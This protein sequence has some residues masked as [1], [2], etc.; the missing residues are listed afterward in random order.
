MGACLRGGRRHGHGRHLVG[1]PDRVPR[2][3]AVS[4]P[5]AG[6]GRAGRLSL[7][8]DP[9]VRG[10]QHRR[11]DRPPG[12]GGAGVR[13]RGR[14]G[15]LRR[16]WSRI[17]G[18][19]RGHRPR[20]SY[21]G[22]NERRRARVDGRYEPHTLRRPWDHELGLRDSAGVAVRPGVEG[23]GVEPIER[24]RWLRALSWS[25]IGWVLLSAL[26]CVA[27]LAHASLVGS[28]PSAGGEL[29]AP[30]EQVRLRFSEPVFAEFDPVEVRDEGGQ[31]VD[32]G[33]ARV[34]P[35]DARAVVASLEELREGS[36]E[37][38]WR[39]PPWTATS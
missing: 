30:P 15:R 14:L 5:V 18:D 8:G 20:R 6:A 24:T 17:S 37:V 19:G 38:Q 21:D 16:T 11:V 22:R 1:G 26:W 27:A 9:D 25:V 3:P 29:S 28:S 32:Q 13:G 33:D 23:A 36:Y 4:R 12:R 10:R 35:Q 39:E 34:D 7:A 2:V 31:R